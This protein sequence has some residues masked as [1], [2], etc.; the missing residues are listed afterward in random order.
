VLNTFQFHGRSLY[1][2]T[3]GPLRLGVE[4]G[5]D[6]HATGF[7]DGALRR[8]ELREALGEAG[9]NEGGLPPRRRKRDRPSIPATSARRHHGMER[10]APAKAPTSRAGGSRDVAPLE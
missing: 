5:V 1:E 7:H 2:S 9:G 8:Q 3:R 10:T 6:H 4:I